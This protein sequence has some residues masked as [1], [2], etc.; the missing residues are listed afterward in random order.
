MT[1]DVELGKMAGL[2]AFVEQYDTPYA[3]KDL[4][5]AMAL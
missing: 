5:A 2:R 4:E 1:D 3:K